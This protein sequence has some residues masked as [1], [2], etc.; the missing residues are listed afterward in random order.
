MKQIVLGKFNDHFYIEMP[1][2]T[3]FSVWIFS[4][5]YLKFNLLV[6]ARNKNP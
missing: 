6:N 4:E 5:D 2:E 3:N 1:I